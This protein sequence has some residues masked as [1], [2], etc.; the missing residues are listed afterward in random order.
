VS[1]ITRLLDMG[2]EPFLL[3]SVVRAFLAQRL[4]RTICSDCKTT[5]VY[6]TEYLREIDAPLPTDVKFYRGFGCDHCRHTGY[7]GRTAIFEI[8][9]VNENLRR[10]VIRKETG[11]AMKARAIADGMQTLRHDGWRRVL[12]GQTTVEEL[13]RVTQQDE[14]LSETDSDQVD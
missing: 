2:I 4:V 9:V 12:K 13:V 3:A 1:G 14:A 5:A 11:T 7:R 10:M 8:V 6:P